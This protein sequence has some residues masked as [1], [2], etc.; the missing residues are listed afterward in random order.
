M[1][2]QKIGLVLSG[3]GTRGVAHIGAIKAL[4]EIGISPTHISGTSVGAAVGAL[5]AYG[6]DWEEILEFFKRLQL[7]DIKKYAL[8]KPGIIDA[9]KFYAEFKTL[10]KEDNFSALK[11]SLTVTATDIIDGKIVTFHE[12]ELIRPI[13]ASSAFPGVFTPV[14]IGDLFY[15]DGGVLNNFPIEALPSDC[16]LLIGSYVN[17]VESIIIE[18][19]K[20]SYQVVERALKLKTFKVDYAKFDQFDIVLYPKE[21]GRYGIF[22]KKHIDEIFKIGYESALETLTNFDFQAT[23]LKSS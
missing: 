3:G 9:E 1:S 16:D 8:G 22:D 5:Y 11:K 2:A 18:E 10:L 12:G 23:T 4:E 15:I 7:F 20:H 13:L 19:V 21:L 17:D 14:Q 6:Y